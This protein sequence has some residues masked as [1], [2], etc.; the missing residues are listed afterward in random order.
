M[1]R[2]LNE[3][4]T[5]LEIFKIESLSLLLASRESKFIMLRI[6][7]MK[8]KTLTDVSLI[9]LFNEYSICIKLIIKFSDV[10]SNCGILRDDCTT[11]CIRS[12]SGTLKTI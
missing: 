5:K 11:V 2:Q 6:I 7:N 1:E 4:S 9:I 8:V 3:K 10:V 12:F